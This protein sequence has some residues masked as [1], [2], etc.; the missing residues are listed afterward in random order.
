MGV[1][2][3]VVEEAGTTCLVVVEVDMVLLSADAA[4]LFADSAHAVVVQCSQYCVVVWALYLLFSYL[5]I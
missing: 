5:S 4:L 1:A 2:Y 3:L